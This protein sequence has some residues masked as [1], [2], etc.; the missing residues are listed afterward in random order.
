MEII[1]NGKYG[2]WFR[3]EDA[4]HCCK[5]IRKIMLQREKLNT[6]SDEACQHVLR[7]FNIVHTVSL[8]LRAYT[9]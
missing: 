7:N 3:K 6:I 5:Q 2:F 1:E 4:E 9:N 8:Y